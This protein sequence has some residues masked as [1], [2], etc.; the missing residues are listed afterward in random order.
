MP[1]IHQPEQ[2]LVSMEMWTTA[3][4]KVKIWFYF[5]RDPPVAWASDEADDFWSPR[6]SN[7]RLDFMSSGQK[8]ENKF[9]TLCFLYTSIDGELFVVYLVDSELDK[10]IWMWLYKKLLDWEHLIRSRCSNVS[11]VGKC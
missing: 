7:G 2:Q 6:K 4:Q 8:R 3:G 9:F 10:R 11:K 1:A 5:Y